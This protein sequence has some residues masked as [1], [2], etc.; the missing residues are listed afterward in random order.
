MVRLIDD[1]NPV[2]T[3]PGQYLPGYGNSTGN[4]KNVISKELPRD[5]QH[6]HLQEIAVWL[7]Q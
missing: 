4:P 7:S 6:V 2:I 3:V 1:N 5:M